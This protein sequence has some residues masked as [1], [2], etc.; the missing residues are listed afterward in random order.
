MQFSFE[1]NLWLRCR[2]EDSLHRRSDVAGNEPAAP[3]GLLGT[4]GIII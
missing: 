4:W 1:L 2:G 3:R